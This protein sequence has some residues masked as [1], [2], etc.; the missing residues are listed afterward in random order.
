MATNKKLLTGAGGGSKKQSLPQDTPNSLITKTTAKVLFMPSA[1]EV[2]GLY[3]Q[4]NPLKSV[5]LDNVPVQNSDGSLNFNNVSVEE[6]YG[7]PSQDIIPGYTSTATPT[8]IATKVTTTTPVTYQTS[9]GDVDAVRVTI[10][11]PQLWEQG[12]N[13]ALKKTSVSFEIYRRLGAGSWVLYKEVTVTDKTNSAAD[14]DYKVERPSGTGTWGVQVRRVTADNS[15]STLANDIFLQTITELRYTN[16]SYPNRAVIGLSITADQTMQNYPTVTFDYVGTKVKVPSNYNPVT[17]TYTGVWDG[18]FSGTKQV[19]DNPAWVLY[20]I[21][22]NTDTGL[23]LDEDNIDKF[24]FYDAAVY[25]DEEVPALVDGVISGTEPR[26][27]FNHQFIEEQ[28]DAW[29]AVQAVAG[30]FGSVVYTNNNKVMLVQD[31]PTNWSR[32]VSNSTVEDGVFTYSSSSLP[33]RKTAAT[34]FWRNPAENWRA[35]PAYYENTS[36]VARYGLTVEQIEG[37]GITTEGQALR[38]AKHIVETSISNTTTVSFTVGLKNADI[39]V[40]EVIKVMDTDYA[41]VSNEAVLVSAVAGSI[42]LDRA[43]TVTAGDTF[44]IVASDGQTVE[45]RTVL[46]SSSGTT[47]TYSG[48]T[49][50]VTAGAPVIFTTTVSPRLFK[51]TNVKA[52]GNYRWQVTGVLYDPN[53]FGRIDSTPTGVAPVFQAPNLVPS[54]PTNLTFREITRNDNNQIIRSL[55]VSWSRPAT[56]TASEY[57]LKWRVGAGAWNIVRASS[58]SYEI[59]PVIIDE[60]DVEVRAVSPAG[61][62]SGAATGSYV[63]DVSGGSTSPLSPVTGLSVIGGG[64]TFDTEDLTVIWTNPTANNTAVVPLRDFLVEVFNGTVLLTSAYVPAVAG[65]YTQTFTFSFTNNVALGGPFRTVTVKVRCRDANNDLS[66]EATLVA[67]NP[68]PAIP[69]GI[70]TIQSFKSAIVRWTFGSEA[71]IRG[72]LVWRGSTADFT[73]S[74]ANLVYDGYSNEYTDGGLNDST[75]YYYKVAAYDVFQKSLNGTGLNVSA[76]FSVTTLAGENVNE[77][78][79]TGVTWTPNS[80]STNQVSWTACTVIQTLGASAGSTWSVSAGSATWTSGVLYIYYTRGEDIFR[81]TTSLGTAIAD[82]KVIVATYRGGTNLEI[83]DGRAFTDGSLIL[84]GTVGASQLVTG[85]A[86]ITQGAQIANAIIDNAKIANATIETLKLKDGAVTD[87][88]FVETSGSQTTPTI[89][90][91]Y[92]VGQSVTYN[93]DWESPEWTS[94]SPTSYSGPYQTNLFIQVKSPLTPVSGHAQNLYIT[95]KLMQWNGS[96]WVTVYSLSRVL[97][98]IYLGATTTILPFSG[99]DSTIF[100]QGFT[101]TLSNTRYK[102][103][104]SYSLQVTKIASTDVS[105]YSTTLS[106]TKPVSATVITQFK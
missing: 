37:L 23:G 24:S 94:P 38:L 11:F 75:T 61:V 81:T 26:Y 12:S 50:S 17:R 104:A 73:P 47:V 77:F 1:G 46:S 25:C 101:T 49:L 62:R 7:L 13:G 28:M 72:Y 80:P 100:T 30:C 85:S 29:Q 63:V 76:S 68:A 54:A 87:I 67:T 55:L 90:F 53:K 16:L 93:W 96:S 97:A 70:T 105:N 45:T 86:V 10:R 71:D 2:G 83:G 21:L 39:T 51:V 89:T 31:R 57:E 58:T 3:D 6:R 22:T 9:T 79:V 5:F 43:V 103:V 78:K 84:A 4:T 92:A 19:T 64:T 20:D 69:V 99:G 59:T 82:N 66:T 36:A 48:A 41:Q 65:G 98:N 8:T 42:T 14:I 40:G 32:I 52:Q 95:P 35:V 44:D 102:I 74:A 56:G 106:A 34:V 60:Y 15:A 27:T 88:K 91:P 33:T 18:S